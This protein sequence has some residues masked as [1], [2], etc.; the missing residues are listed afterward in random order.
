MGDSGQIVMKPEIRSY[1]PLLAELQIQQSLAT[2]LSERTVPRIRPD[3][4][5]GYFSGALAGDFRRIYGPLKLYSLFKATGLSGRPPRKTWAIMIIYP[6]WEPH[7]M[8]NRTKPT[9]LGNPVLQWEE[10][11][12]VDVGLISVC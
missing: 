3:K 11:T 8:D 9:S 7:P 5:W 12:S 2:I 6:L 10:T 1:Q 4:R